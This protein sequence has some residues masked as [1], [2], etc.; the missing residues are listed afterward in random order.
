MASASVE[1]V[2][3]VV[4]LGVMPEE[5][6]ASDD[7]AV[8]PR[9]AW[10]S[11][12][13]AGN[14]LFAG[15]DVISDIADETSIGVVEDAAAVVPSTPALVI[16]ARFKV[17]DSPAEESSVELAVA[18]AVVLLAASET[19]WTLF[20]ACS[21]TVPVRRFLS[22]MIRYRGRRVIE[23]CAMAT[24]SCC[25]LQGQLFCICMKTQAIHF[26]DHSCL[27]FDRFISMRPRRIEAV[28]QLIQIHVQIQHEI[29]EV[30]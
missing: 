6:A 22:S 25:L 11:V 3:A 7:S 4:A 13:P 5:A 19:A 9:L 21:N 20:E 12:V 23:V 1:D 10:I 14:V 29:S 27:F 8:E 18:K 17:E 16:L 24:E 30:M 28:Q 2:K 26:T 15:A